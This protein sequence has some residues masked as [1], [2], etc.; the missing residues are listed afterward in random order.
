MNNT[1]SNIDLGFRKKRFTIDG[2]ENRVLEIDTTDMGTIGRFEQYSKQL[3]DL[4][5]QYFTLGE[6]LSNGESDAYSN[7]LK[8]LDTEMRGIIDAVFGTNVCDV[9]AP[10]G[11]LFDPVNGQLKFEIIIS[12]LLNL[13]ETEMSAELKKINARMQA[14]LK[15]YKNTKSNKS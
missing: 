3:S 13:Y 10:S 9:C 4:S 14:H 8:A 15:K 5:N 11:T 6:L 2:D 7:K 12:A 1:T